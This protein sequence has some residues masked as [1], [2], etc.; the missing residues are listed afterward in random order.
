MRGATELL[1][2]DG[3]GVGGSTPG[4]PPLPAG[5]GVL[6]RRVAGEPQVRAADPH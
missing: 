3:V 6:G 5:V 4:L 1:G 2:P